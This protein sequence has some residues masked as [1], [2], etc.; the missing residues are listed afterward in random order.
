MATVH[1]LAATEVKETAVSYSR[2][3]TYIRLY[4]SIQY[5]M[6][7]YTKEMKGIMGAIAEKKIPIVQITVTNA[8]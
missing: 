7:K 4:L 6:K 1:M 5:F 3:Y 8:N 2:G